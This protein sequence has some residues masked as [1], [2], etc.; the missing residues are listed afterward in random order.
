MP[1]LTDH[2]RYLIRRAR[3]I[4]PTLTM[5]DLRRLVGR[6]AEADNEL[7]LHEAIGMAGWLLGELADRLEQLDGS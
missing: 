6:D 1:Q 7:V 4:P 3:E 2:D 5:A